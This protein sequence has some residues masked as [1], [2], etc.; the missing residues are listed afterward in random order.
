ML[1][2]HVDHLFDRA[3]ISFNDDGTLLV[4]NDDINQLLQRWGIDY[5]EVLTT[6]KPFNA[7]QCAYLAYH[8]QQF[9][10]LK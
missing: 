8:R 7:R 10:S 3:Y 4:L 1:S 6:S 9:A 2:P 5:R